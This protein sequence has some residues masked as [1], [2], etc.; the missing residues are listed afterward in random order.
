LQL[1]CFAFALTVSAANAD[2]SLQ[3]STEHLVAEGSTVTV[4]HDHDVKR[5]NRPGAFDPSQILLDLNSTLRIVRKR[6]QVEIF[7]QDVMPFTALTR[8]DGGRYFAGLSSLR[9]LSS[10]YNF[11]LIS[12]S[13]RIVTTA[14]ITPT[15]GHCRS[16]KWSTTNYIG[17][18]DE[19]V[20][21]VRLSFADD[22]VDTVT[23]M[24]PFDR[25]ADG[26]VGKCV[27]RVTPQAAIHR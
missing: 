6:D 27:I 24:N 23:V 26:A 9:T 5:I 19:K 8:A 25:T 20:P 13:G 12:E 16:V 17:W 15:S 18:F 3:L 11:M 1:G 2:R 22:K 4:T 14:L 7:R 21:D 10:D